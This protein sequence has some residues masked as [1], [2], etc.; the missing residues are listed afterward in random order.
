MKCWRGSGSE[1][2][3][4][5]EARVWHVE[6]RELWDH[7]L[8]NISHS[9]DWECCIWDYLPNICLAVGKHLLISLWF[10]PNLSLRLRLAADCL[11]RQLLIEQSMSLIHVI[12]TLTGWEEFSLCAVCD[13]CIQRSDWTSTF[14]DMWLVSW[15]FIQNCKVRDRQTDWMGVK[16]EQETTADM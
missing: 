9:F 8:C 13:V 5:F 11:R 15:S 1:P 2:P 16:G 6:E 4:G 12:H 7:F 10:M 14:G 3:V